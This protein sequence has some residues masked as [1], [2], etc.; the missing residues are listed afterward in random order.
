M[1]RR[2]KWQ[3]ETKRKIV[4]P[5]RFFAG[6]IDLDRLARL[7]G[8]HSSLGTGVRRGLY[9]APAEPIMSR[10][11]LLMSFAAV[12]LTGTGPGVTIACLQRRGSPA[13]GNCTGQDG[14]KHED[15]LLYA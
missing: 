5:Q 6:A 3:V 7:Y 11:D 4:F 12:P 13:G 1:R 15:E 8:G 2:E 14:A 10:G 9:P